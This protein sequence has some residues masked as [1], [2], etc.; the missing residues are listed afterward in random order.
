MSL[1]EKTKGDLRQKGTLENNER[2]LRAAV[3]DLYHDWHNIIPRATDTERN[4]SAI[5][6]AVVKTNP[7]MVSIRKEY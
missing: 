5:W 6:S 1:T 3:V 2:R 7:G 4:F